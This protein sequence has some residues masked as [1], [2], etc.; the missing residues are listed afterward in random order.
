[1]QK[2]LIWI[3]YN[4]EI[5]NIFFKKKGIA[6]CVIRIN[7]VS[8][9]KLNL[10][11]DKICAKCFEEIKDTYELSVSWK[12]NTLDYHQECYKELDKEKNVKHSLISLDEDDL[13]KLYDFI[14]N[15]NSGELK[16]IINKLTN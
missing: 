3:L 2:Y 4:I 13:Y 9:H 12:D 1:M 11:M 8:L 6:Y 10:F 5:D 16:S 14:R 15:D 7:V